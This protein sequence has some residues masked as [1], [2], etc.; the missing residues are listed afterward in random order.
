MRDAHEVHDH[1]E[2]D[3]ARK[4]APVVALF[5]AD[6]D[7]ETEASDGV[8]ASVDDLF[9]R[10]RAARA[11]SIVERAQESDDTSTEAPTTA[12]RRRPVATDDADTTM[13]LTIVE[14]LA[15][16][17]AS[18]EAPVVEEALDDTVFGQRDA[19]LTPII[20]AV[21]PQ[22]EARA[23]RRAERDLAHA[24]PQRAGPHHRH[25]A[26][27]GDR[28]GLALRRGHHAPSSRRPRSSA[29]RASTRAR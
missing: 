16:F 1:N 18:P 12:S 23:R 5:G 3:N 6:D 4:A 8:S 9:A 7:D 24:A 29:P 26:A 21:C 17:Q 22:A 10:L 28:A 19:S 15:V 11:E 14:D 25:D 27:L 20:V 2:L 13:M